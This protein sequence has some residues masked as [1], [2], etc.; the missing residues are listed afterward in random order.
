MANSKCQ[1]PTGSFRV[2]K[3]AWTRMKCGSLAHF[4]IVLR[5]R[6]IL[7]CCAQGYEEVH[8]KPFKHPD[9][10][11]EDLIPLSDAWRLWRLWRLLLCEARD[12]LQNF[13]AF[14]LHQFRGPNCPPGAKRPSQ[15]PPSSTRC[16]VRRN[17]ICKMDR[18]CLIVQDQSETRPF[19]VYKCA[20]EEHTENMLVRSLS[21]KH[22]AVLRFPIVLFVGVF[23][24]KRN[25]LLQV[26][27]PTGSG[28]T[29][30]AMLTILN[31]MNQFRLKA[32][33]VEA[34]AGGGSVVVVPPKQRSDRG[35]DKI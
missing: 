2:Q 23:C 1:L 24:G 14:L 22:L 12:E 34:V 21:R 15:V 10:N 27:A 18:H 29:N 26:C 7:E 19:E 25:E 3:K 4:F 8:V 6:R 30:V 31:V 16:R 5:G 32:R 20:F 35:L 17:S 33:N 28:K 9:V 13:D 11:P